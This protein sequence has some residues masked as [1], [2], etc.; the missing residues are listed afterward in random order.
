M[1]DSI[2]SG[3]R[4]GPGPARARGRHGAVLSDELVVGQAGGKVRGMTELGRRI[5][6]DDVAQEAGVSTATVSRVLAG[7]G[8]VNASMAEDVRRAARRLGYRP[9]GA[10]RDLASGQLRSIGV[11]VPDLA[12]PYF[13]DVIKATE[14]CAAGEGY[15]MLISDTGDDPAN[16]FALAQ[17][18]MS[19][20]GGLIL[21]SPRMETEQLK[22][23]VGLGTPIVLVNRVEFGV[24]LPFVA[25]DNFSAMLEVCHHLSSLGHSRAVYVAGSE[26]SWQNRERW[27]AIEQARMMGLEVA[28]VHAEPTIDGG[29]QGTDEALADEPTAVI[30][31]NDL[32]ACGVLA[33]L[34]ELGLRVPDD[35][36]VTGFDDIAFAKYAQPPLMT[37]VTPRAQLGERAWEVL[38]ARLSGKSP[39][40]VPLLRAEVLKRE[41]TAPPAPAH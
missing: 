5:T 1:V 40:Q 3:A 26:L 18:L 4:R 9:L 36:S 13:Y 31:F 8:S 15:R 21:Q 37:V 20:V 28:K 23:L 33:R 16:E 12:N 30:A 41:S 7:L 14:V 10:A 27:R 19:Q 17:D 29:Y 11:I 25:V 34:R 6:I 22:E 35:I 2:G 32:V 39:Q 24:D 38:R